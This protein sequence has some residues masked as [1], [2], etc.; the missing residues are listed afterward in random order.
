M[1]IKIIIQSLCLEVLSNII[2]KNLDQI[3][4]TIETNISNRCALTH[5]HVNWESKPD[6]LHNQILSTGKLFLEILWYGDMHSVHF[7]GQT[8]NDILV[9]SVLCMYYVYCQNKFFPVICL[10]VQNLNR[11]ALLS[12]LCFRFKVLENPSAMVCKS[13]KTS[14]VK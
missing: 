4:L 12:H 3:C 11:R 6:S 7:W 1:L 2:I 10:R 13:G 9:C 8:I 5:H 14:A